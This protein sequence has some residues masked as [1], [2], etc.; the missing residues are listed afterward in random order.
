MYSDRPKVLHTLAGK[1]LLQH[2]L[3]TA[4]ALNPNQTMVV[5]GYGGNQ[6]PEA[7][8]DPD[9]SWVAQTEQL[10]T[11]HALMQAAP[12]LCEAETTLIL[13]GDVP[14]ITAKTLKLLVELSQGK[15]LAILT[16]ELANADGYGRIVR[17]ANRK[18]Q[19]IVEHKDANE[20]ERKIREINTG[21]LAIPTQHLSHWVTQLTNNNAQ[22]EY[23]LTDVIQ[24]AV[25]DKVEIVTCHPEHEWEIMGVNSKMQLAQLERSYQMHY[26]QKLLE[27]GVKLLDP[28]RIDVRGELVCGQDVTIDVNCIFEGKVQL[29]DNVTVGANSVIRNSRIAAGT[30]IEPFSLID[31]AEVGCNSKIGPFSRIRPGTVLRDDVHIGNFVEIKNSQIDSGSKINHLSY[32]GDSTVGKKVNIG[33]GTITC[34]YDGVNK[35]RTVIEDGA[36]IGSD[37]QLVAPVTVAKGATIGAGSTITRDAPE[38]ELTL[39]RSKQITISGWKRPT[40]KVK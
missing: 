1:S 32:I 11:G 7:I 6:V 25:N 8:I 29:D 27:Q 18:V 34:N 30:H 33:A 10:G 39:S 3:D 40:K 36:F 2:V 13:Y 16:L 22:K 21:I 24:M 31:Q 23:Y 12:S 4:S 28:N 9:I 26:A 38:A 35:H 5:Y 15:H 20:A 17:G 14:L 19:R 37:T